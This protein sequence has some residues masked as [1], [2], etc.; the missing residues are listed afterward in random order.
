MDSGMLSSIP[1]SCPLFRD[2]VQHSGQDPKIG[3]LQ[4]G[5]NDNFD[6]NRPT[7][8]NGM[9]RQLQTEWPDNIERNTHFAESILRF[10]P[11]YERK[12]GL[13]VSTLLL[14]EEEY[15]GKLITELSPGT[16][17]KLGTE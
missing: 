14:S 17:N 1:G 15:F 16:R 12:T 6:R 11:E 9:P 3:Q 5:I 4:N 2:V 7:T 8:S 13:K 10:I